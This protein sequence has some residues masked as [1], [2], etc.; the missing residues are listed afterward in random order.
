MGGVF[1]REMVESE[2]AE[3]AEAAEG[4]ASPGR[5]RSVPSIW[6]TTTNANLETT[7]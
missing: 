2:A 1:G 6:Q 4:N 3:A 7:E 5:R